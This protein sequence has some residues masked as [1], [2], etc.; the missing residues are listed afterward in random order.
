M[1]L[2]LEVM[3]FTFGSMASIDIKIFQCI[4]AVFRLEGLV[5]EHNSRVIG[6]VMNLLMMNINAASSI[7]LWFG[8]RSSLYRL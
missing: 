2:S 6:V 1:V 4:F 3:L 5:V 8:D 7:V